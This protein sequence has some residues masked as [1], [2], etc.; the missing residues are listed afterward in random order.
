MNVEAGLWFGFEAK[1]CV[2]ERFWESLGGIG[3]PDDS[4]Q[5]KLESFQPEIIEQQWATIE[6]VSASE[7]LGEKIERLLM[8]PARQETSW[9][10][11]RSETSTRDWKCSF[12]G[13][14]LPALDI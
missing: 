9:N 10:Q 3:G 6:H 1:I 12:C 8:K 5:R 11:V 7:V 4:E 2:L 13:F 14:Y